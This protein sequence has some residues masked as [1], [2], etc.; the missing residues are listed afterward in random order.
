M[1]GNYQINPGLFLM[2]RSLSLLSTFTMTFHMMFQMLMI[3][4]DDVYD[5]GDDV[6]YMMD[7][8]CMMIFGMMFQMM[9]WCWVMN[10]VRSD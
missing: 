4:D 6:T 8:M 9:M 10:E 7:M 2:T 3:S 1:V 5:D